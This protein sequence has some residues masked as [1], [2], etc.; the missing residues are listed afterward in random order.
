[1]EMVGVDPGVQ[2]H[3]LKLASS[4]LCSNLNG[5]LMVGIIY[6]YIYIY[7]YIIILFIGIRMLQI[8]F[9]SLLVAARAGRKPTPKPLRLIPEP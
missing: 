8:L 7:I 5:Q 3:V 2:S 4:Q 9:A 6:I 1:M